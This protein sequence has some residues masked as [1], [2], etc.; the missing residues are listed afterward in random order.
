MPRRDSSGRSIHFADTCH[1]ILGDG[2]LPLK[3]YL[4]TLEE[5]DYDGIVDL[6]I[7]PPPESTVL[8]WV[9]L[10][11]ELLVP[12]WE[13]CSFVSLTLLLRSTRNTFSSEDLSTIDQRV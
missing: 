8:S 12:P 7:D 3:D 5:Y 2:E 10:L 1:Y 9:W 11:W 13:S 6:E 4:K